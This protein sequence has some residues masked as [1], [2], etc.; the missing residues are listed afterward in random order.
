MEKIIFIL[1]TLIIIIVFIFSIRF[2]YNQYQVDLINDEKLKMIFFKDVIKSSCPTGCKGGVCL[3]PGKCENCLNETCCCYDF[4]CKNCKEIIE[5]EEE[6]IYVDGRYID[7]KEAGLVDVSKINE[8][9]LE[10]NKFIRHVN[11]KVDNINDKVK[12]FNEE[13]NS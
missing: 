4:Q 5:E 12:A 10:K 6:V 13:M 1:L 2:I 7:K 3:N 8:I 9:V 11:N